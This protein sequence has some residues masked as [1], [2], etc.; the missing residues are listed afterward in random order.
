MGAL[1]VSYTLMH[2]ALLAESQKLT[3]DNF[4]VNPPN[5]SALSQ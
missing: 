2:F 5:N 1:C 4:L 3:A